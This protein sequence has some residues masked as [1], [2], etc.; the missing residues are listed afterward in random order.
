VWSA[1]GDGRFGRRCCAKVGVQVSADAAVK[2]WEEVFESA[3][4]YSAAVH[5]HP[6]EPMGVEY[7]KWPFRLIGLTCPLGMSVSDPCSRSTGGDESYQF[8]HRWTA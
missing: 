7:F 8:F 6:Q 3:C 1:E 4:T 2:T 5:R